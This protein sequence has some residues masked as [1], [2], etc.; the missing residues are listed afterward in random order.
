VSHIPAA[1][2]QISP[3]ELKRRLDSGDRLTLLDVRE[4]FERSICSISAAT[5]TDL[6]V[7]MNEIP[8]QFEEIR[9]ASE[10][11]PLV[12]YCHHGVR[13]MVAARWL[14]SRGVDCL[15]LTGGIDVW[16]DRVDPTLPRY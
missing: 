7:P 12:V 6:N 5:A 15:N 16:T 11:G 14:A 4:E 2:V 8:G 13:S 10:A 3:E 1:V 9:E